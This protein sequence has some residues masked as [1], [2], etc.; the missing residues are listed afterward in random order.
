MPAAVGSTAG[1]MGLAG[2]AGGTTGPR[3]GD[4]W[5]TCGWY[6]IEGSCGNE[7]IWEL[8]PG[9][10]GGIDGPDDDPGSPGRPGIP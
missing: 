2:V 3:I 4:T 5:G 10:G 8:N 7:G 1:R 9:S 6:G